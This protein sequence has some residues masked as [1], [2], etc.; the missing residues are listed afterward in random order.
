[1]SQ[2][3]SDFDRKAWSLCMD[4]LCTGKSGVPDDPE[5][6]E[7]LALAAAR[8]RD[9][10]QVDA[11][12][13]AAEPIPQWALKADIETPHWGVE[14]CNETWLTHLERQIVMIAQEEWLPGHYGFANSLPSGRIGCGGVRKPDSRFAEEYGVGSE[15][16]SNHG[17]GAQE[18]RVE[19]TAWEQIGAIETAVPEQPASRTLLHSLFA[20]SVR[21]CLSSLRTSSS[22]S[23]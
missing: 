14:I 6:R 15:Q 11:W 1:M 7:N 12:R 20:N 3:P 4:W 9:V 5:K 13:A 16:G 19:T 18:P 8:D 21:A 17:G 23:S 10:A 2:E 22:A